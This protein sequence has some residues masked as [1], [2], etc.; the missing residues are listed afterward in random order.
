V[1]AIGG[2][3]VR[4]RTANQQSQVF[5]REVHIR[6]IATTYHGDSRVIVAID[7]IDQAPIVVVVALAPRGRR[8]I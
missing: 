7:D 1:I 2:L 4:T 5:N 6:V 8:E 3:K